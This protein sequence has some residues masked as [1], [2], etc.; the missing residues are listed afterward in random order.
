[1]KL[2]KNYASVV[3]MAGFAVLAFVPAQAQT[4][5]VAA[6]LQGRMVAMAAPG[7]ET[8]VIRRETLSGL[9]LYP[10]QKNDDAFMLSFQQE[11]KEAGTLYFTNA[12]GKVLFT[13]PIAAGDHTLAEPMSIGKLRAGIY[14]VEVKTPTT[15]YWKKVRVKLR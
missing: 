3:L 6:P 2:K 15:V 12:S 5:Q 11:M 10:V 7:K 8:P 1:M 14:L 9:D 13:K 4:R